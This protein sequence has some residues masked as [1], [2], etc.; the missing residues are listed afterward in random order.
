[1]LEAKVKAQ[2]QGFKATGEAVVFQGVDFLVRPKG[3]SGY[4][5][6]LF[7]DDLEVG[8]STHI[9][10]GR[11]IPE[12][13]IELRSRFLWHKGWDLAMLWADAWVNQWASVVDMSIARLDLAVDM[14]EV[15]PKLDMI[16]HVV[17]RARAKTVYQTIEDGYKDNSESFTVGV[18]HTGYRFGRGGPLVARIY[19]KDAEIEHSGKAWMHDIWAANGWDGETPVTRVEFQLRRDVLKEMGIETVEAVRARMGDLWRYLSNDWL[20]LVEYR[21]ADTNRDRWP[22]RPFWR[23]VMKAWPLFG[24][25][26]DRIER[27]RQ[28]IPSGQVLE[29]MAKGI[30]SSAVALRLVANDERAHHVIFDA[31]RAFWATPEYYEDVI[32]KMAKYQG[33]MAAKAENEVIDETE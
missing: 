10:S 9:T 28:V 16:K 12:V 27:D 23:R 1:M 17:T 14:P 30:M 31:L 29:D 32:R 33:V 5:Y 15:L 20:R 11:L 22:V 21:R 18:K 4:D 19:D 25:M 13:K 3:G 24:E 2:N 8:I 7:N 26:V 6:L